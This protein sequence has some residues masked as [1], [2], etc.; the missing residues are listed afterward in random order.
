L[1]RDNKP[2]AQGILT[3]NEEGH[4]DIMPLSKEDMWRASVTVKDCDK[5]AD[6]FLPADSLWKAVGLMITHDGLSIQIAD[7]W[8]RPGW[9]HLMVSSILMGSRTLKFRRAPANA[10]TFEADLEEKVLQI[11]LLS[12]TRES[13]KSEPLT[14]DAM[15]ALGIPF[16]LE[17]ITDQLVINPQIIGIFHEKCLRWEFF[18][19]D[20]DVPGIQTMRKLLEIPKDK[21]PNLVHK[22]DIYNLAGLA[23]SEYARRQIPANRPIRGIPPADHRDLQSMPYRAFRNDITEPP[24]LR[25]AREAREARERLNAEQLNQTRLSEQFQARDSMQITRTRWERIAP[26]L[27]NDLET[28]LRRIRPSR[29]AFSNTLVRLTRDFLLAAGWR[30]VGSISFHADPGILQVTGVLEIQLQ[31]GATQ[32]GT[33]HIRMLPDAISNETQLNS[34][35]A[36]ADELFGR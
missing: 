2:N 1:S 33:L 31:R 24:D 12:P 26:R 14:E 4:A 21:D 10:I 29:E 23:D 17:D 22:D 3:R 7:E 30:D 16:A 36:R 13:N 27:M 8:Y 28:Q 18:W 6:L 15:R 11:H 34:G 9:D 32:T 19:E 5:L 20:C 35:G 25:T